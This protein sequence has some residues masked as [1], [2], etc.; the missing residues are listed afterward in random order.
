MPSD[1]KDRDTAALKDKAAA[2]ETLAGLNVHFRELLQKL[3]ELKT[4]G[5]IHGRFE[6]ESAEACRATIEETRAWINSIAT[7]NLRD[8]EERDR[9]RFGRLRRQFERKYD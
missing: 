4:L 8:H 6:R 7:E 2:Y 3:G 1:H 5:A 9:A